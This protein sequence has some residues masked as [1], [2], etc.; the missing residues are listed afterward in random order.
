VTNTVSRLLTWLLAAVIGVV[1]GTA[2]TV[3]HAFTIGVLPVGLV[4]STVGTAAL[5]IAL[6]QLTSNR[7]TALAGGLGTLLAVVVFSGVGPGGSAIVAAPTVDTEWIPLAWTFV[8]PILVA[9]VIAWPDTSRL[10]APRKLD[11]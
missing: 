6:R 8:V 2:A 9:L 5:L 4:L 3:A 7:W 1:Y 11:E 10:P